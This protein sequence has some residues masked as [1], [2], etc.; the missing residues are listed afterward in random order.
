MLDVKDSSP[1]LVVYLQAVVE[2]RCAAR[3]GRRDNGVGT[4]GVNRDTLTDLEGERLPILV[5]R[6]N[7]LD[8]GGG[9]GNDASIENKIPRFSLGFGTKR[10]DQTVTLNLVIREIA[11]AKG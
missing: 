11:G 5:R 8:F 1:P 6:I 3:A 9:S 4:P 2:R 7:K 10:C